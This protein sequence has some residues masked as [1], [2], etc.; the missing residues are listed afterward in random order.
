[1]YER[2]N[3]VVHGVIDRAVV[4]GTGQIVLVDYKTHRSARPDNLLEFA[5]FYREQMQQYADGLRRAWPTRAVRS[6]L[7]FTSCCATIEVAAAS[8]SATIAS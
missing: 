5:E 3:R 7:L 6:V 4:V 1:M 2:D 8:G